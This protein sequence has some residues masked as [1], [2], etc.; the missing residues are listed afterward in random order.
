MRGIISIFR[1]P[2]I[3]LAICIPTLLGCGSGKFFIPVCQA[4]N[5]CSSSGGGGGGGASTYGSYAYIANATAIASGAQGTLAA[6]P[7]PKQAFTSLNGSSYTLGT[8]PS[9]VA[10]SPKGTFL[11]VATLSGTVVVYSIGA[12]G[13]LTGG[14]QVVNVLTPTY[15]TIDPTGNWLFI[16]ANNSSQLLVFQI[17]T[18]TGAVVQTNQGTIALSNGTPTQVYVTPN[19]QNVYVGLGLGGID[20]FSFSPT[21]GVLANHLHYNSLLP[22]GS[23]DNA[24]GSDSKST[25]LFVGEAGTGIRVLT[26]GNGGALSDISGSPFQTQ[27]GPA[28]IVVDPTNTYLYVANRTANVITGYTIGSTGTLTALS[29][30][31]FQAGA[32]PSSMSLDSTGKYLLV[33]SIN[34]NPDLE[35]FSFDTTTAGKLDPVASVLTGT[36]PAGAISLAVAP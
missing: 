29:S 2:A 14:N 27:L 3:V 7:I 18:A 26:I 16:I 24:I 1:R 20:S 10:A 33:T 12:N 5:T 23:S 34:G 36:D 9:A 8:P 15:M 6:F 19:G 25:Y 4:N 30:S 28:A 31:P 13:V 11:Y 32:G 35:V 17:D 22:G 21:N